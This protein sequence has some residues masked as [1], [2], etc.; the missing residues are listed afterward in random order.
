MYCDSAVLDWQTRGVPGSVTREL[1]YVSQVIPTSPDASARA[2]AA[3]PNAPSG[4]L[5]VAFGA[6]HIVCQLL[7]LVPALAAT[8]MVVR[9]ATF[10]IGLAFILFIPR[11]G[12]L[13]VPLK[14]CAVCILAILAL[15]MFHPEGGGLL[16]SFAE[17]MLTLAVMAPIFWLPRIAVSARSFQHL[18]TLLWLFYTASATAGV[19]QV[20]FPGRFQPTVSTIL[21]GMGRDVVM[22]LQIKLA[23]GER[24]FRPMGLTNVPGGA[25]YGGL[26][27]VLLGIGML[28]QSKPPFFGG[29]ILAFCSM[30]VGVMCLYLCQVRSVLI[31]TGVCVITLITLLIISGRVTRLV[32]LL[33]AVGAVAQGA[34][35]MAVSLGGRGVTDRLNTLVQ[36][37]AGTVYYKNRG[38]FLEVT[39]N[40]YLPQ[41]PLGAGLGR[42]GMVN[43]YFGEALGHLYVEIQWTGWLF[44]GGVPLILMYT[45]ALL[46][47]TWACARVALRYVGKGEDS[48]SVWG[49]VLVAYNAGTLALCFNYAVFA[50]TAG[51]EFWLLNMALLCAAQNSEPA[52]RSVIAV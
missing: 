10:G 4:G 49:A 37:D 15:E 41:F 34:F 5:L 7:L 2:R 6:I 35:I 43:H 21:T 3:E 17:I 23:S 12:K 18:I 8:R 14:Q 26:F 48:L 40:T 52:P 20:M 32:G 1:A 46:I 28:L 13:R 39:I 45:A 36:S 24:M 42:W 16:A 30:V 44:D 50:G 22:S 29:R 11:K 51:V 27:A 19:L 33:A 47:T 9:M 25:A 31:M 38:R